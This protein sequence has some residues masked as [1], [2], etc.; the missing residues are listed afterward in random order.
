MIIKINKVEKKSPDWFVVS[1]QTPDG[2]VTDNA[3]VNR[4][5]KKGEVFPNFDSIVEG[6]TI[7]AD[8]WKSD[9]GKWYVFA[10]KLA[11]TGIPQRSGGIAKQAEKLMEIKAT[12]VG[13]S[14]ENK[15]E[16]IK[17]T[18]SMQLA[19]QC[20]LAEYA[21]PNSLDDLEALIKKY[22]KFI[23]NTWEIETKDSEDI[24]F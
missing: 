10:P 22:R 6:S 14:Q 5:N 2:Y 24:P 7:E 18:T 11:S 15:Q 8:T 3:S 23:L 20:A 1:Y 16:G 13:I 21:K 19:V 12:N 4:T 17:I 9:S